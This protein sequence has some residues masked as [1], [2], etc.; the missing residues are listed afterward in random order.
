MITLR[1]STTMFCSINLFDKFSFKFIQIK[2]QNY[3]KLKLEA[4]LKKKNELTA[5]VF[6]PEEDQNLEG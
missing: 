3:A 1:S 2:K 4:P 5:A 6:F